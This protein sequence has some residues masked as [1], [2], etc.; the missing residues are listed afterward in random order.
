MSVRAPGFLGALVFS[1]TLATAG[2]LLAAPSQL[3]QDRDYVLASDR[4]ASTS[5]P[6]ILVDARAIQSPAG[7]KTHVPCEPPKRSAS[8]PMVPRRRLALGDASASRTLRQDTCSLA[9]HCI[10]RSI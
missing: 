3:R 4:Q 1:S 8:H 5:N 2:R 9:A 7:T 10:S 6:F